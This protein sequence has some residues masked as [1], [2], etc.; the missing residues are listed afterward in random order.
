[1]SICLRRREFIAGLGGA[2]TAW[3]LAARLMAEH[4]CYLVPTLVTY[5]QIAQ[6]GKTNKFPEASLRKLEDVLHAGAGAIETALRAGV[7]VGFG[8]DLLGETHPAQ[9]K[10]FALRAQVQDNADILHSATIINADLLQHSGRLGILKAGA[11]AD[12]LLVNGDPLQD[13][14]VLSGQG[15]RLDVIVRGRVIFKNTLH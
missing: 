4:S 2:V 5:D 11:F 10:E 13:L 15:E 12:F 6:F 7:K 14:A 8:T 9:S 1:M 3:P